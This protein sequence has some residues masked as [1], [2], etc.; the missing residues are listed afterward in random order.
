MFQHCHLLTLDKMNRRLQILLHIVF[1]GYFIISSAFNTYHSTG[2]FLAALHLSSGLARAWYAFVFA[3][4]YQFYFMSGFYGFYFLVG[5]A[6][7]KK[8]YLLALLAIITTF[9]GVVLVRFFF[10]VEVFIPYLKFNN[11]PEGIFPVGRYI[12]NAVTVSLNHSLFGLAVYF[13]VSTNRA[14]KEKRE[15]EKE[16]IST[17]LSFLKSQVN[18]HFLFNTINDVY[19][20]TYQKSDDAPEA[21]LKLSGM[22]R[23]MIYDSSI[24]HTP[25]EKEINYLA[26]YIA[27]QN[28]GAKKTLCVTL[29]AAGDI[30]GTHV[31]P[32]LLIPFVENIYKHGIIDD[33]TKPALVHI[34]VNNN[35]LSVTATNYIK[36]QNKDDTGGIGLKNISRRLQLQYPGKHNFEV[37]E[38]GETFSCMLQIKL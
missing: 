24:E 32:M 18:P 30:Q 27:L 16:K 14:D 29:N 19:A 10:E 12:G 4:G 25:L 28:I 9:M 8:Q 20:L 38:N 23:Y 2:G 33:A 37:K 11:Y 5:P 13:I 21:L 36:Q 3:F 1:W 7:F 26:D 6:L 22:L 17:E 34:R 35:T 15:L 31:A